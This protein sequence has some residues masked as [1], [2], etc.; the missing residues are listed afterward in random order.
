MEKYLNLRKR[1]NLQRSLSRDFHDGLDSFL[2][3]AR[4]VKQ[5]AEE[6]IGEFEQIILLLGFRLI[7][8]VLCR[9]DT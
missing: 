4:R 5:P 3:L 9:N 1:E 8:Y 6:L 7:I 2:D